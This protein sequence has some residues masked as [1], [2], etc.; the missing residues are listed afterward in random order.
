M[1]DL[2][3]KVAEPGEGKTRWLIDIAHKFLCDGN[4]VALY[5]SDSIEFTTF[6]KKYFT[7]YNTCCQ[8]KNIPNA[9]V[10]DVDVILIDNLLKHNITTTQLKYLQRSCKHLFITIEGTL[11]EDTL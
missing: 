4:T 3:I 2:I 6:C 5:T 1:N 9:D 7:S 11:A 10:V 8:I